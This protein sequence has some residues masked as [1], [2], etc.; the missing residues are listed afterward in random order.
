MKREISLLKRSPQQGERLTAV[1]ADAV[2]AGG[3]SSVRLGA[4]GS[5]GGH[6]LL[7][8][9]ADLLIGNILRI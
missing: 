3:Q 6:V 1:N 5:D 9:R 7:L 4:F 2:G 8:R